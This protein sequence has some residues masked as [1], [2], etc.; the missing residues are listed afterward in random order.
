MTTSTPYY[1]WDGTQCV[2]AFTNCP[3]PVSSS[4]SSGSSSGMTCTS[5]LQCGPGEICCGALAG[6]TPGT[7]CQTGACAALPIIGM[8]VQ[9]CASSKECATGQLC[10]MATTGILAQVLMGMTICVSPSL[11]ASTD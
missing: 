2:L 3:T 8:A 6:T 10:G 11:D 5:A 4:S 7:V 1:T 9:F